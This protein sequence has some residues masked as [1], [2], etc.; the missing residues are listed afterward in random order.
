MLHLKPYLEHA[1]V[2]RNDR[3]CEEFESLKIENE[4][5]KKHIEK[6]VDIDT[7]QNYNIN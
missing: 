3:L 6:F 5:Y 7:N 1:M 2:S 4:K